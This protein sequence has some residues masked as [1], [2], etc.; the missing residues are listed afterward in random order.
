MLHEPEEISEDL[1]LE[2][3]Q[4]EPRKKRSVFFIILLCLI[5]FFGGCIITRAIFSS[6]LPEDPTAYDPVTLQPKKPQ[7]FFKRIRNLVAPPKEVLSA[8]TED[9]VNILLLGQGGPG[10]DG[11]YLTDTIIIA[12]VNTKTKQVGFTS[13]PRDLQVK[14]PGEGYRKINHANSFGEVKQ[15]GLGPA[16]AANV[17]QDTFDIDIPYYILVDFKAFEE[18]LNDIGGVNIT[19]DQAFTDSQYPIPG[20]E[21]ALPE[22]SRYKVLKFSAG[23]QHMDG[24]TAL[25]FIR[26]RHGSNGEGSDY[27]RSRRQQ[28][29]ILAV[30]E[31]VLSAGTLFNPIRLNEILNSLQTHITTNLEFSDMVAFLKLAREVDTEHIFTLP[32]DDSPTG[33]LRQGYSVDGAFI[34]QPKT[35]NFDAINMAID[36]LFETTSTL[37]SAANTSYTNPTNEIFSSVSSSGTVK[38]TEKPKP[39]EVKKTMKIEVKNGTWRE[40]LAAR[41]KNQ[42][43]EQN[44]FIYYISN[45]LQ[46]P[47]AKSGLYILTKS[48]N[49]DTVEAL[50]HELKIPV[51]T[52]PPGE[53]AETSTDIL[54]ILGDDYTETP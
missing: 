46:R 7:G 18:I 48:P 5:F 34:L 8:Q 28:K 3:E 29:V 23:S 42:L 12:S 32:L 31:K 45:T 20:R 51:V 24:D 19:V 21:D 36:H 14:I 41:V 40:G 2:E 17:I 33:Y 13:I 25:E 26:S 9:R 50:K 38:K 10:H 15:R 53:K 43:Q 35:G 6:S 54:V 1:P 52:L 27:A 44:F 49:V 11:P 39:V 22:S 16:L 47:Q 30:K 37:R 4:T